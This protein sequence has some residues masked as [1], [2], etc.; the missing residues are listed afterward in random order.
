M[1]R[2]YRFGEFRIL[3]AL[4]ELWRGDR[5]ITLPPQVFDCLAYLVE[6]ND[7]A[8]GHDELVAAVWGK[9]EISEALLRQAILRIRRD[10]GDDAKEQRLLRTLPRFGYRWIAP[11]DIED[12][13]PPVAA[14]SAPPVRTP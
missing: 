14:A 13:T 12:Y 8:V 4:R 1:N 9:T 11:L 2:S 6:H 5:L 7:R 10:L 3:P